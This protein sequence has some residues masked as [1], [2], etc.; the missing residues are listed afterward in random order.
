MRKHSRIVIN[1]NN[2]TFITHHKLMEL[3][4]PPDLFQLLFKMGKWFDWCLETV[5]KLLTIK[6]NLSN[7]NEEEKIT[8]AFVFHFKV[9]KS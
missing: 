5:S 8:K 6:D 3:V 4:G 7:D 1:K 2:Y 9:I